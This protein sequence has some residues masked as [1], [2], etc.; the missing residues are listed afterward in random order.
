MSAPWILV[1]DDDP[2]VREMLMLLL[3][4]EGYEVEGA[5]DGVEAL[6]RIRTRGQPGLLLLDLRMPR[7]SGGELAEVLRGDPGW[8]QIP[9]VVL[10]GDLAATH[11]PSKFGAVAALAK[12]VE[13]TTLLRLVHDVV[14]NGG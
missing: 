6:E 13:R 11:T 4:L 12:P 1:A 2:D 5:S 10:S 8:S 9:I 7:M 3:N 14:P